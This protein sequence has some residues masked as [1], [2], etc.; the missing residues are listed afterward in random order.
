MTKT[1]AALI[2]AVAI[3]G[4]ALA[5]A[6]AT[7][8]ASPAHGAPNCNVVEAFGNALT[9]QIL[10]RI[11]AGAAGQSHRINRRKTLQI[12]GV[13]RLSFAGCD[14][15]LRSQVT[16]K[17]KVRRDARGHVGMTARVVSF[18]ATEV[19]IADPRVTSVSLSR[20]LRIGERVYRWV[21]GKTLPKTMCFTA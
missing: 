20:T 14:V 4:I 17:R 21:A 16:L 9:P 12:V 19:C 11:N 2:R 13:D 15:R 3:A 8:P 10:A 1:K 7:V 18:S 5:A 6:I